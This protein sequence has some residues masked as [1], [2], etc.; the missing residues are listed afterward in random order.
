MT[1]E[2]HFAQG[3]EEGGGKGKE[4]L[5]YIPSA[6]GMPL[7]TFSEAQRVT[8]NGMYSTHSTLF[9]RVSG[10]MGAREMVSR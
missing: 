10:V 2:T 4:Y 3:S 7:I 8:T 1:K 9:Q 6:R 5:E